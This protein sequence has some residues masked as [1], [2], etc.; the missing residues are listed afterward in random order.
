[1]EGATCSSCAPEGSRESVKFGRKGVFHVGT[2]NFIK[3]KFLIVHNYA[4]ACQQEKPSPASVA[5]IHPGR[6]SSYRIFSIISA[7]LHY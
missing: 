3:N 7:G 1:M 2:T 6:I 5:K 4:Y